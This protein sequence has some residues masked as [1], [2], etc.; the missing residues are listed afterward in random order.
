MLRGS[1]DAYA[2]SLTVGQY[3]IRKRFSP[4]V[5]ARFT[6]NPKPLDNNQAFVMFA[7]NRPDSL[8]LSRAFDRGLQAL[9]KSGRYAQ[10]L[11]EPLV[12]PRK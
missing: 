6:Y 3:L 11:N 7:R 10:I 12:P 5:A 4:E 2:T 8:P 1:I 9:K